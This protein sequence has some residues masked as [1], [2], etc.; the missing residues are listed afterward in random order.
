M[1]A[2]ITAQLGP[3]PTLVELT[4][5]A[6]G[7]TWPDEALRAVLAEDMAGAQVA[8]APEGPWVA[9]DVDDGPSVV[10]WLEQVAGVEVFVDGEWP[11]DERTATPP[12]SVA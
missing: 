12:G 9:A 3:R 6:G 1:A 8:L 4:M 7:T 5:D 11:E 10:A 2:R